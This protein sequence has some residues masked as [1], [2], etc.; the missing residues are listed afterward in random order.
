MEGYR[1]VGFPNVKVSAK[2]E[3][4]RISIAI[5]EGERFTNGK[6]QVDCPKE[7]EA[8][9]IERF[10]TD[11]TLYN[12]SRAAQ[13]DF[14]KSH[15][16][17]KTIYTDYWKPGEPTDFFMPPAKQYQEAI[18]AGLAAEGYFFPEFQAKMKPGTN[19]QA[20]L[21]I[22]VTDPGPK[23]VIGQISVTG[24][25]HH[26]PEDLL[27]FLEIKPG[28]AVDH[29]TKEAWEKKLHDSHGFLQSQ[30]IVLPAI[31]PG[32]LSDL[33]IRL[34]EQPEG[35]RLGEA[36]TE[37][38]RLF[39]KTAQWMTDW[40]HGQ[41]GDLVILKQ[42]NPETPIQYLMIGSPNEGFLFDVELKIPDLPHPLRYSLVITNDDQRLVCWHSRK[43]LRAACQSGQVGCFFWFDYEPNSTDPGK[44]VLHMN[45]GLG[46]T[47]KRSIS[48]DRPFSLMVRM[49][50]SV[51]VA[52]GRNPSNTIQ[53]KDGVISVDREGAIARISTQ[54]G[55]LLSVE[56]SDQP[57]DLARLQTMTAPRLDQEAT[58][59]YFQNGAFKRFLKDLDQETA[60]IPS[61]YN[62]QRPVSS[63]LELC[64]SE[65]ELIAHLAKKPVPLSVLTRLVELDALSPFDR[66][67]VDG[68]SPRHERGDFRLP[69]KS[70]MDPFRFFGWEKLLPPG[71]GKDLARMAF[72]LHTLVVPPESGPARVSWN[73]GLL[74]MGRTTEAGDHFEHLTEAPEVGPLTCWYAS[75]VFGLFH[76]QISVH[77]AKEG[78][79]KLNE[80]SF[81]REMEGLLPE[82][83]LMV[84]LASSLSHAFRQLDDDEFAQLATLFGQQV[85]DPR[86]T[87][88]ISQI[89]QDKG[90]PSRE[91]LID[92]FVKVWIIAGQGRC[93]AALEKLAS[94]PIQKAGSNYE[95]LTLDALFPDKK[96]KEEKPAEKSAQKKLKV[97]DRNFTPLAN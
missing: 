7:I 48:D 2:A 28:L 88:L 83:S 92:C 63:V 81:R 53:D 44:W 62:P 46:A 73:L 16:I 25:K 24:L 85:E 22:S 39:A 14:D 72:S 86:W 76:Q 95:D 61:A 18:T 57:L 84:E 6:V 55:E 75:R 43:V 69:W 56:C 29:H 17:M 4:E 10:L 66:L 71:V 64:L 11:A 33:E 26:A 49:P 38:D 96:A 42:W 89:R 51:A 70:E 65:L 74:C 67:W 36:L 37:R 68:Q 23:A 32:A 54:T 3:A 12:P 41:S 60:A 91:I 31:G 8:Q 50:P 5:S 20:D 59:V 52:T 82:E 94:V 90:K 21:C 27:K 47:S 30:I 87:K 9:V 97:F 80:A 34:V 19:G 1:T 13:T 35:P 79:L 93:Q 40:H 77:F 45:H 58:A 15:S 78:L